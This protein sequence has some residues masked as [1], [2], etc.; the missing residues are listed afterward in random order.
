MAL[1]QMNKSEMSTSSVISGDCVPSSDKGPEHLMKSAE[2]LPF[3]IKRFDF[4]YDSVK[5]EWN[6]EVTNLYHPFDD[7]VLRAVMYADGKSR[8]KMMRQNRWKLF[9][10][11]PFSEF[12]RFVKVQYVNQKTGFVDNSKAWTGVLAMDIMFLT[13]SSKDK[14]SKV[15]KRMTCPMS[16]RA[17]VC[18]D[19]KRQTSLVVS[20]DAAKKYICDMNPMHIH[21]KIVRRSL[22][23]CLF[24]ADF[25]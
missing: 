13:L 21:R 2:S 7:M 6:V 5:D 12:V 8:E 1:V 25:E 10:K 4:T 18:P 14:M 20:F 15:A 22:L 17:P 24:K 3:L 23:P 11:E 9:D 19:T 16:V